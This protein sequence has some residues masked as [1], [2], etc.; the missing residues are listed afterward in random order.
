MSYPP[1][2]VTDLTGVGHP[3]IT[4]QTWNDRFHIQGYHK[5]EFDYRQ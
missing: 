2:E 3:A 5:I 4:Q 1:D